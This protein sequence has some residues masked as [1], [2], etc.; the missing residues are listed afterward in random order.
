M[1]VRCSPWM[2]PTTTSFFLP[3]TVLPVAGGA[4]R[5]GATT[6][7]DAVLTTTG[8]VTPAQRTVN[9]ASSAESAP[10]NGDWRPL[11]TFRTLFRRIDWK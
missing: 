6:V 4:D 10:A 9:D 3:P 1:L 11:T 2:V 5:T 8:F 7:Y